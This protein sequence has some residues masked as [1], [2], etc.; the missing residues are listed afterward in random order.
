MSTLQFTLQTDRLVLKPCETADAECMHELLEDG[1]V[2]D[3][4]PGLPHPYSLVEIRECIAKDI[5]LDLNGETSHLGIFQKETNQLMGL[6]MLV[7]IVKD[8]HY[9][10]VGYWLG[11][12]YRGKGYMT[13]AVKAAFKHWFDQF[14]LNRIVAHHI[15]GNKASSN[16]MQKLGM[17]KEGEFV[18]HIWHQGQYRNAVWYG[19]LKKDFYAD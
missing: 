9:A 1:S 8:H 14:D 4:I 2:A 5:E 15:D 12:D 10:E 19:L 6:L 7:R 13:E 11:S 17:A 18:Q 16:V 3:V